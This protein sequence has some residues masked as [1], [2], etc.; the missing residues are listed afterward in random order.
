MAILTNPWQ[1]VFS[2]SYQQ[3][4]SGLI[5]RMRVK[6]PEVTDHSEGNV[7]IILISMWASVA[8]VIHYYMD[9]MARESFFSTAR[10]YSSLIKHAKLV[11]YHIKA[12]IPSSADILLQI[13]KGEISTSTYIIPINTSFSG[14]NGLTYL[15]TKQKT[16]YEGTYGVSI[17]VEQKVPI[18]NQ[19]IGIIN[20]PNS[21]IFINET[22][23]LYVEGSAT[24][25]VGNNLWILVETFGYSSSSD[26]HFLVNMDDNQ[27]PYIKFG[28]GIFGMKPEVNSPINLSYYVTKGIEGNAS[29]NTIQNLSSQLSVPNVQVTNPNP[30]SGGSNYEDFEMLKDHVPL[31][32]RT[33][34]VAIT[35]QDY[36]D[37]ARLAP[38]IDKSYIDFKCGK[39]V[40]VYVVPDG[41]GIAS[42][43]LLDS[44][45]KYI[46]TKK[47]VTTNIR[48]L[49]TGS[50]FIY[51]DI[52]VTGKPSIRANIVASDVTK[53]LIDAYNFNTS[54]INKVVRLSDIYA[55]V[56]NVETVE[57][58]S[59]K[60]LYTIPYPVAEPDVTSQL[61]ISRFTINSVTDTINYTITYSGEDLF[62][63]V[64]DYGEVSIV[65]IGSPIQIIS[66]DSIANFQMLISQPLV[67]VYSPGDRWSIKLIPDSKDQ[68]IRDYSV[69]RIIQSNLAI[70]VI[71]TV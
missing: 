23:G 4:K 42:E 22:E 40:N 36:E 28:D 47:I 27:R 13:G 45:Q 29:E 8:E 38:G 60:K 48:V 32:I 18:T 55:L 10:R 31:S 20:D 56:D 12:A 34:G 58:L 43:A 24:L 61:N 35:K 3:I 57:Y 30:A 26:R 70:D 59:I 25:R 50:S 19:Y 64:S 62:E 46:S 63:I 68:A 14:Q 1:D 66:Q 37:V 69:P 17:P 6:L 41:G 15:S 39:F 21:V 52:E 67:G 2:R 9:N 53:A 71:E 54:G 5:Q 33:L 44:T 51:L 7:F 65:N 49:P 11:D 16:F